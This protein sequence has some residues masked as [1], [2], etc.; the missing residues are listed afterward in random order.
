MNE[1]RRQILEMLAEG[2]ISADEAEQLIAALER[3]TE[4]SA[5]TGEA[6]RTR[7]PKFLRVEVEDLSEDERGKVNIRVPIQLLRAGVRLTSLIPHK[8]LE[9]ANE[10]MRRSGFPIDLT[11]LKPEHIEDLIDQL[12]E[13]TVDVDTTE[14]KVHIF[15]E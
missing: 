2:K 7:R 15:C 11:Q 9:H 10:E 4:D 12:D 5:P 3:D 13:M 8:A 14:A 6:R 1:Q